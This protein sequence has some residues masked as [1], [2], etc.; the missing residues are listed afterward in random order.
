MDEPVY[1]RALEASDVDRCYLW[2]NDR[3][4]YEML[5]GTFHFVSKCAVQEWLARKT[6]FSSLSLD[7][8]NLAICVNGSD[9]HVGNIYLRQIDWIIRQGTL[10]VFIGDREERSKSYGQSAV[11]QLLEY[12]F[13]ELGL[14]SIYLYVLPDNSAAIHVY[15]KLGFRVEGRRKNQ[16]FKRGAWKDYVLMAV[17]AEE[18]SCDKDCG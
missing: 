18:Y 7:E 5:G 15:E 1:L 17:S 10:Q 6:A 9:K 4:L 11:R 2:H 13:G 12:A 3:S 8:I 14:K 16:A